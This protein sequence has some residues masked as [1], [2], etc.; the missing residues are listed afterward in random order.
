MI[1][2]KI[3]NIDIVMGKLVDKNEEEEYIPVFG[4]TK[5]SLFIN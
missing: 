5:E 1:N 4:E 2:L 3:D